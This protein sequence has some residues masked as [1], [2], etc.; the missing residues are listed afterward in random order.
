MNT[1]VLAGIGLVVAAIWFVSFNVR[2]PFAADETTDAQYPDVDQKVLDYIKPIQ[3]ADNDDELTKKLKER[4]NVAASLV[5]AQ[6]EE[7]KSGLS[8]LTRVL[9]AAKL[10]AEAKFALAQDDAARQTVL[11]DTLEIA[12][13]IETHQ[14]KKF[15]AGIGSKSDFQRARLARINVELEILKLKAK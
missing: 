2:A 11:D 1:K 10:V 12:K 9:D 15:D 4:H 3:A 7:Y 13:L 8:D 5:E 6:V 14:Q